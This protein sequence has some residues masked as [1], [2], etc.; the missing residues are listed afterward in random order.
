MKKTKI[1]RAALCSSLLLAAA[2]LLFAEDLLMDPAYVGFFKIPAGSGSADLDADSLT[3]Y[4]ES[5]L[6]TDPFVADTDRDG[7]PDAMDANPVSRAHI[8]WGNPFFTQPDAASI[9]TWP[10]WMLQAWAEGGQWNTNLPYAWHSPA[11]E[12]TAS[13]NHVV[14]RD[15]IASNLAFR[16]EY[17][18]H[19]A[20]SLQIDLFNTNGIIIATNLFGNLMEGL[21]AETTQILEI[22]LSAHP[23]AVG[24]Q[25]RK[26]QGQ[27]S[28]YSSLLYI[29]TDMDGLDD[30]QELQLGRGQ[31]VHMYNFSH[32]LTCL[33][34]TSFCPML[35]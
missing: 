14:D 33:S 6:W 21:E 3:N 1:L 9:Y 11:S 17:F 35:W 25:L 27:A 10:D 34:Q 4:E 20:S 12:A 26:T 16:L 24:I 28:I 31:S 13:L 7:F 30:D 15:G 8:P 5:L 2:G 29:D 19:A 18:D 22:P 32:L 23:A